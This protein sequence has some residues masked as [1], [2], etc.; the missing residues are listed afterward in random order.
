MGGDVGVASRLG[1]GST[2][3]LTAV[4]DRGPE[5]VAV[6][7][8]DA[9]AEGVLRRDHAGKRILLVEDEPVN[10]EVAQVLLQ[11]VGL[12]IDTAENGAVAVRMFAQ[13]AYDLILM[14]MQMPE[15]DGL[16]ASRAIRALTGGD[17]IPIV[18]MTANAFASDREK[19]FAAGMSDFIAKPVDPDALFAMLLKWLT[20]GG[21]EKQ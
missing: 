5:A 15:M 16:E 13:G 1:E 12:C 10:R 7:P 19:C 9:A 4:V 20:R 8:D 11:D 17:R 14:D 21:A 3:W 18:A 2:F 6:A